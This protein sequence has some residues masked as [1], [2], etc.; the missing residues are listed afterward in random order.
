M[1]L[2]KEQ[3]FLSIKRQNEKPEKKD[4]GIQYAQKKTL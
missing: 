2:S 1:E 3:K 4:L